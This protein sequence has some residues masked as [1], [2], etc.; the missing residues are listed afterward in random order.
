[1]EN[2]TSLPSLFQKASTSIGSH[3]MDLQRQ[4]DRLFDDFSGRWAATPMT[5]GTYWPPLEMVETSDA[6][7]ITAELPGID[8]KDVDISVSGDILTIKGEKKAE[9]QVRDR[10]YFCAE[11]SYGAFSRS[12]ELP[13]ELDS[14]KVDA[15]YEKGVLRLHIAKP[16][17]ARKEVRKIAI[18]AS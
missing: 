8:P 9:K 15:S 13:F 14:A 6:V 10:D 17:G 1:M 3:M 2:R 4:I 18:K 7:D 11:R 5:D 12:L 16:A